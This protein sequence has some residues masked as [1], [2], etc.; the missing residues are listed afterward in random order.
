MCLMVLIYWRRKPVVMVVILLQKRSRHITNA[1]SEI[2]LKGLPVIYSPNKITY[3]AMKKA[4][5]YVG[6]IKIR[7]AK[8]I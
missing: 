5:Q 7:N 2:Q 3:F 1:E 8:L 4:I 6:N